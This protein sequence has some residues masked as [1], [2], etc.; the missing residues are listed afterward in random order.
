M[1]PLCIA[2]IAVLATTSS[3]GV[4]AF[5]LKTFYSRR[6]PKGKRQHNENNRA[7]IKSRSGVSEGVGSS[8]AAASRERE[9]VDPRS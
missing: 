6:Q 5:T 2:N 1:C 3:G 8:A 9:G 7:G 4:A